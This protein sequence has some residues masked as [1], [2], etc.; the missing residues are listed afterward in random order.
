MTFSAFFGETTTAK[1]RRLPVV[2]GAL[3]LY[4]FQFVPPATRYA[5]TADGVHI[6]YH[7]VGQGPLDLVLLSEWALPLEG[8]WHEPTTARPLADS[9]C[10]PGFTTT[11]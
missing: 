5:K 4:Q 9:V 7:V 10:A 6:A 1:S 11:T 2:Y 8:R 3:V